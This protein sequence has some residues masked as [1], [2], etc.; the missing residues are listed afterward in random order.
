M[1]G[2]Q[3]HRQLLGVQTPAGFERV[4]DYVRLADRLDGAFLSMDPSTGGVQGLLRTLAGLAP[5]LCE[6][7]PVAWSPVVLNDP[8]HPFLL[9]ELQRWLSEACRELCG[10]RP[11]IE[12]HHD[13]VLLALLPAEVRS[14][15][16]EH[17]LDLLQAQLRELLSPTDIDIN[18]RGGVTLTG[19]VPGFAQLRTLVGRKA[20]AGLLSRLLV[21]SRNE[22]DTLSQK[23]EPLLQRH[24]LALAPS[25]RATGQLVPLWASLERLTEAQLDLLVEAALLVIFV[26]LRLEQLPR[27]REQAL[28]EVAGDFR[29]GSEGSSMS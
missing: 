29:P 21:T 25:V 12:Q 23:L 22:L 15:I 18:T 28:M 13:G 6:G 17:G 20:R 5:A 11:L 8:H 4:P 16:V 26:N 27:V 24:D 1:E 10:M 9:D 19:T 14:R 2:S 7:L 3:R